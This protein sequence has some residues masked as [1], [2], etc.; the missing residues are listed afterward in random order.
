MKQTREGGF[1]ADLI[2]TDENSKDIVT[3]VWRAFGGLS[4]FNRH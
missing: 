3:R 1:I 2:D 4:G